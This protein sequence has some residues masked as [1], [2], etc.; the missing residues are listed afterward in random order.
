MLVCT[1]CATTDCLIIV[2]SAHVF[3]L[4]S[5]VYSGLAEMK[6]QMESSQEPVSIPTDSVQSKGKEAEEALTA[7]RCHTR[8]YTHLYL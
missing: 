5:L 7:A 2:N 4:S 1:G 3:P 6:D 8:I